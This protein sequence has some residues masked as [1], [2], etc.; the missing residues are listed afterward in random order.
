MRVG[1]TMTALLELPAFRERVHP[2]SLAAS[3]IMLTLLAYKTKT[4]W[5]GL[6]IVLTSV[7]VYFAWARKGKALAES[8]P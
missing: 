5:P 4:T 3:T 8:P 6:V 1:P 7:P 2:I